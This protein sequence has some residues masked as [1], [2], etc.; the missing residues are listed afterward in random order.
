MKSYP[1]S[2]DFLVERPPTYNETMEN[3]RKNNTSTKIKYVYVYPIQYN[4]KR[5]TCTLI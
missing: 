1:A 3:I 4:N 5:K 2:C